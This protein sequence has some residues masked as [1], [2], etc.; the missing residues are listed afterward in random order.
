MVTT[1]AQR[2]CRVGCVSEKQRIVMKFT[3]DRKGFLEAYSKVSGTC[4]SRSPKEVLRNVMVLAEGK[5]SQLYSTNLEAG[6]R[7]SVE[8]EVDKPGKALLPR[9]VVSRI[10]RE[11][12]ADTI[13]FETDDSSNLL[14]TCGQSSFKLHSQ[15]PDEFPAFHFETDGEGMAAKPVELADALNKTVFC[16]D[17]LSSRFALGAVKMEGPQ[18]IGTDGRRLALV[19]LPGEGS[20]SA[21]IPTEAA[22]VLAKLASGETGMLW[23]DNNHVFYSD[24][25]IEFFCRQTEGRYPNWRQVIPAEN[26]RYKVVV[27]SASLVSVV[28]QASICTDKESRGVDV[29][30][31]SDKLKIGGSNAETGKAFAECAASSDLTDPIAAKLDSRFLRDF[32][33]RVEGDVEVSV[34]GPT[35]PIVLKSSAYTYVLMPMASE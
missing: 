10:L 17:V 11:C 31:S 7:L 2:A 34:A 18:V 3:T 26:D 20:F 22:S 15:N 14:V 23:A 21:M 19:D 30:F 12:V 9:D 25:N 5:L 1:P 27:D 32:L 16:T 13:V 35:Q 6:V 28:R 8:A 24:E 29:E 33:E 4:P